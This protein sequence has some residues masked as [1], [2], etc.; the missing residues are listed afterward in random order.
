MY[1][2]ARVTI[3]TYGCHCQ[4]LYDLWIM[5]MR[6][7]KWLFYRQI[8]LEN[9][10]NRNKR[11]ESN[12]MPFQTTIHSS[13]SETLSDVFAFDVNVQQRNNAA[14]NVVWKDCAVSCTHFYFKTYM[15]CAFCHFSSSWNANDNQLLSI[16]F[17]H[18]WSVDVLSQLHVQF[19]LY[20]ELGLAI[21]KFLLFGEQFYGKCDRCNVSVHSCCNI[22]R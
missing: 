21:R 20:V 1:D 13:I 10:R 7:V 6:R 15:F 19:Y 11:K 18:C 22:I 17:E 8:H 4:L 12:K 2:C 3:V 16:E 5:N 9:C 14:P